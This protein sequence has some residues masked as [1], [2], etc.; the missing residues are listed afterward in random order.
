MGRVVELEQN[1]KEW[2]DFRRYRIGASDAPVI[3]NKSPYKT[4]FLLWCEFLDISTYEPGSN[5]VTERGHRW[6]PVMRARQELATGLDFP[7]VVMLHDF[8]D[9]IMCSMDGYNAE[10]GIVLEIKIA[11]KEVY[12]AALRNEVHSKY[13]AQVQLQLLISGAKECRF[14]VGI[15][16]VINGQ[17]R[18]TK[19]ALAI[20]K[21]DRE[22]Q[23]H[24]MICLVGFLF[25]VD[26]KIQ[27]PLVHEDVVELK[28]ASSIALFKS[29]VKLKARAAKRK[30]K[31]T[32]KAFDMKKAML[33]EQ[34]DLLARH[35]NVVC[36]GLSMKKGSNGKWTL[37]AV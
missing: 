20:A 18:I 24:L 5:L 10:H 14:F 28:D 35:T 30:T 17:E 36:A 37:R 2:A 11:G 23:Q 8:F 9:R 31:L 21:P 34:C 19:T 32:K 27:P 7:P 15:V 33:A 13:W 16:E 22:Y 12:E 26:N 4:A 6:E 29:M 3:M 25:M 1:S